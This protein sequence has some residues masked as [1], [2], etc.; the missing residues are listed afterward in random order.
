MEKRLNF[1]LFL[2]SSPYLHLF[3]I[4]ACVLCFTSRQIIQMEMKAIEKKAEIAKN[5][6]KVKIHAVKIEKKKDHSKF[7]GN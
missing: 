3:K 1:F 4:W 5:E 2:Q 7:D 6:F